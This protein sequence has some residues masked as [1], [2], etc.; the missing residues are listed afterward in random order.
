MIASQHG[1][2]SVWFERDA[3][4]D[5]VLERD[6]V[7]L[8]SAG[9]LQACGEMALRT[10]LARHAGCFWKIDSWRT[11]V[12]P[13][14]TTLAQRVDIRPQQPDIVAESCAHGMPE[15]TSAV[16]QVVGRMWRCALRAY[17]VEG[18]PPWQLDA[19]ESLLASFAF[20]HAASSWGE[21]ER[22]VRAHYAHEHGLS[23]RE[24]SALDACVPFLRELTDV[25][26]QRGSAHIVFEGFDDPKLRMAGVH[27]LCL[28]LE[29]LPRI[30]LAPETVLLEG[31]GPGTPRI[32]WPRSVSFTSVRRLS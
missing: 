29:W 8:S 4:P 30:A 7:E 3:E 24:A 21:L 20:A 27:A 22:S 10:K 16:G 23:M 11:P 2:S 28:A 14:P 32:D 25:V 17:V 26:V 5:E 15:P 31:W 19:F 18:A 1:T 6:L 12:M 13:L 9:R